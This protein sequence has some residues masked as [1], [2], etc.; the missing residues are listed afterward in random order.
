MVYFTSLFCFF[1]CTPPL[2]CLF[3]HLTPFFTLISYSHHTT[4]THSPMTSSS[5]TPLLLLLLP[6]PLP[7]PHSTYF[8]VSFLLSLSPYDPYLFPSH[9]SSSPP[10]LSLF[11][12]SLLSPFF[13]FSPFFLS[14]FSTIPRAQLT[15]RNLKN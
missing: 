2:S 10:L 13:S 15:A 9:P 11:P 12:L 4:L 3:I 8:S 6:F 14:P 7:I 1:I 5:S